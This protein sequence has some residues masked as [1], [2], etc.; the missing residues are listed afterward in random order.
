M[1]ELLAP[2]GNLEKLKTA[3]HFGADAVYL[4]GKEFGL[5]AFSDNF[6]IPELEDAMEIARKLNKKVYVTANIFARNNDFEKLEVY[7]R[8][9][10][11]LKVSGVLISDPGV[12]SICKKVA[13]S[14]E[15]HLST[16]ANTTNKHT[17]KF[18][19]E[20][21]VKRVVL[22]RELSLKE[23]KEI[24]DFV[25]DEIELEVFIH[26]A[27][28]ISYS[29]RCLL[30]NYLT[31]RDSNRGECVQACR[32]EY[33]IS[34]VSRAENPLTIQ[35]DEKGT[36]LLNSKDLN[37]LNY[38]DKLIEI[39]VSSLKIEGRMKSPFYVASVVNIYRRAIDEYLNGTLSE[40]RKEYYNSELE[41]TSHR[42]FTKA[43]IDGDNSQTQCY[44]TSKP[45]QAF[46]FMASVISYDEET[47]I[48]LIE[49]RNRFKVGDTLTILSNGESFNCDFTVTPM[50]DEQGK[51]VLDALRVQQ[52]LFIKCPHKLEPFDILTMDKTSIANN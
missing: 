33:K 43:F 26:G 21:G 24:K 47:K 50:Q 35:Q 25:G 51:E 32:W 4:G 16:Q 19:A 22:A 46:D 1:V 13:P 15:I 44:E 20:Q 49:Q 27:M 9:L 23:I 36:Y 18:W 8:Q 41:K 11:K 38:I 14:L 29:G 17:V 45:T 7:F 6:S 52:K 28:C 37:L 30:S 12:I 34:E 39:G 3:F 48:A 42:M 31:S 40:K 10:E 5:R 2:A